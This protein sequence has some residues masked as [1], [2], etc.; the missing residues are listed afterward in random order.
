MKGRDGFIQ[1]FNG[2]VVVDDAHQVIVAADVTNQPPDNGNLMPMLKQTIENC[3]RSPEKLSADAGYWNREAPA[4]SEAAGTDVYI[5]TKRVK[6][7]QAGPPS[8]QGPPT[9]DLTERERMRWKLDTLEGRAV[10]A[11]RKAIVEPVFGQIK[12]A[13]G[14]RRFSFRGLQAV[15]AEWNLVSACHNLLKLY[16]AQPGMSIS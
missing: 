12:A 13:M 16:R 9:D 14:F 11:R 3:G 5:S 15:R 7:G 2:Q 6:H 4:Q 1:G 10:Y 8:G